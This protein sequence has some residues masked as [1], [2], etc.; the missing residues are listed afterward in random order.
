VVAWETNP[1]I[2]GMTAA[3]AGVTIYEM[4]PQRFDLEELFLQLTETE[5]P[6]R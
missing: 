3:G 5:E 6:I 2:V 4:T 1:E